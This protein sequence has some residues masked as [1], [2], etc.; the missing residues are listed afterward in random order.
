MSQVPTFSTGT[1]LQFK[2]LEKKHVYNTLMT[3]SGLLY[4]AVGW[5]EKI[6]LQMT[7]SF[8]CPATTLTTLSSS[9]SNIC[10]GGTELP[11][12][13]R[14]ILNRLLQVHCQ[15]TFGWNL[16][17]TPLPRLSWYNHHPSPQAHWGKKKEK[18]KSRSKCRIIR[19]LKSSWPCGTLWSYYNKYFLN[20][21][22]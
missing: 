12:A 9:G 18:K 2:V 10:S 11:F 16:L 14:W 22:V 13:S 15:W 5:K 19:T 20:I 21:I 6:V 7:S 3:L 4:Q 17:A 1:L 8:T